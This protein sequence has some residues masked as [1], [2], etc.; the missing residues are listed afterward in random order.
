MTIKA[1]KKAKR[2]SDTSFIRKGQ[3]TGFMQAPGHVC[4][5]CGAEIRGFAVNI[6]GGLYR[7]SKCCP[8]SVKWLASARARVS[9]L[10]EFF[11][12]EGK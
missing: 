9:E 1:I 6:L 4:Y 2:L 10:T 5:V 8:G 12:R 7:H 3:K 11:E